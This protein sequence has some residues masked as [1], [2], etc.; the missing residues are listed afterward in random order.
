MLSN[1][2]HSFLSKDALLMLQFLSLYISHCYATLVQIHIFVISSIFER[3]RLS[4]HV[5]YRVTA[6]LNVFSETSVFYDILISA[7]SKLSSII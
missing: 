1:C 6:T 5:E 7:V 2:N 3:V 4:S